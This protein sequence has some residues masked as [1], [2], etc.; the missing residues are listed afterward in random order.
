VSIAASLA[1]TLTCEDR[2]KDDGLQ[3]AV[4]STS[5]RMSLIT[6]RG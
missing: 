4:R 2:V 1:T 3:L 5:T 6:P